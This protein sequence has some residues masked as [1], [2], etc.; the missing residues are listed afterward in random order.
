MLVEG[1]Y[2]NEYRTGDVVYYFDHDIPIKNAS[3][4]LNEIERRA[5]PGEI[6]IL[7]Q[8]KGK[9]VK[10]EDKW[11]KDGW[12]LFCYDD[13][14]TSFEYNLDIRFERL[15]DGHF[16][17]WFVFMHEKSLRLYFRDN[18]HNIPNCSWGDFI[19]T[20][21]SELIRKE[22][23]QVLLEAAQYI[24][25]FFHSTKII[26]A[27]DKAEYAL[28]EDLLDSGAGLEHAAN[29]FYHYCGLPLWTCNFKNEKDLEK[30]TILN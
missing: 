10:F 7:Q 1:R 20:E 18:Y 9:H 19:Q 30:G 27:T 17:Q 15:V 22:L 25:P 28:L 4:F 3:Q 23:W 14:K 5:K 29:S 11:I 16:R 8:I 13:Y 26:A 6:T 12:R 24:V 2:R 21:D